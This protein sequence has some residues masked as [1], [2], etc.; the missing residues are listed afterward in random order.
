MHETSI[1]MG[2]LESLSQLL[3]RE[4]AKKVVKVRVR[5]GKLSGI[6]VDS[7]VFAFDALKG[8]FKGLEETEL[9]VEESPIRYRCNSCGHEFTVETVFF[10]ECPKCGAVDLK[11]LSGEELQVIDAE[12]EV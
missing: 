6:V 2:F 3:E 5:I 10:P 4:K 12:I 9:V 11:L 1:A 8:Q 7:F